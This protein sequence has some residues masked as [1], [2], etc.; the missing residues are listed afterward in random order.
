MP[1]PGWT[2]KYEWEGY[3]PFDELPRAFNPEEGYI[4]TAN[5]AVVGPDY[6]HFIS[7]DWSPG[8][9]ARRIVGLIEADPTLSVADMEAIQGNNSPVW[10]EDV[11]P[12]LL[13]LPVTG[14]GR[15]AKEE[16]R[17]AEALELLRAWDRRADR[18]S[19]GAVL[20]EEFRLR[21]IDLTFG[22]ELGEQLLGRAR[23][24]LNTALVDLL[25]EETSPWFDKVNTEEIETRDDILLQ[26][27][28]EAVERLTEELGR[29][30]DGWRWG[31]V[32]TATFEN[33]SLGKCDIGIVESIFNRGPVPV[34]G[35]L[36]TVNNTGYRLG[37]PYT[38]SA[39]PSYRQIVDLGDLTRS[40]SM[41]TTG[42]SGHAYHRHYDDMIDPWRNIEYHA[43][44]WR[45]D[46]VEADAEG[47]LL[48]R[49]R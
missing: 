11:L 21:L 14:T 35:T 5:N 17:L 39:V 37:N 29:N 49:P 26:A 10:A 18:E 43:M 36:S 23:G 24:R 31:D 34:D 47:V 3:I 33:Q 45:R 46:D 38:V 48:L 32:H 44:L 28:E 22:D 41:H 12:H 9:R 6:P 16:R 30:M 42:Q 1:V 25:E 2:D 8:Y 4:V 27:L 20:F 13:V 15:S 40:I 19:A 7:M